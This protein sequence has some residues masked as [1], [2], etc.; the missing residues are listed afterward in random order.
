MIFENLAFYFFAK[1]C[2]SYKLSCVVYIV[3]SLDINAKYKAKYQSNAND[4]AIFCD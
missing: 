3:I 4:Q 1:A 2:N